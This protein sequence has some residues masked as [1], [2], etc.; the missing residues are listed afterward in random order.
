MRMTPTTSRRRRGS[1]R[2]LFGLTLFF[3]LLACISLALVNLVSWNGNVC[4]V[5]FDSLR[6]YLALIGRSMCV[7]LDLWNI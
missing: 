2:F 3:T 6:F 5:R 7:H 4:L 1:V